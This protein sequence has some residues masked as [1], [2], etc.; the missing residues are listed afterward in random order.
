M[1]CLVIIIIFFYILKLAFILI[2]YLLAVSHS[3]WYPSPLGPCSG[4]MES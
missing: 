3:L 1:N 4:N 2:I